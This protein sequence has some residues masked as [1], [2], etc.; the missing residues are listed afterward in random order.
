M[1]LSTAKV[2]PCVERE[3]QP[4]I[5][6]LRAAQQRSAQ[7]DRTFVLQPSIKEERPHGRVLIVITCICIFYGAMHGTAQQSNDAVRRQLA[8]LEQAPAGP[9][10]ADWDSLGAYRV[11]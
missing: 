2:M 9:F 8:R 4:K 3:K 5:L 6:R 1:R 10:K 11:P 7:D